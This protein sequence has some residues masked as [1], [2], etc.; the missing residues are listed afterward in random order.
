MKTSRSIL[1]DL[2]AGQS[3]LVSIAER[4][5]QPPSVLSAFLDD[6]I[7][8]GLV[9]SAPIGNPDIGR[10]LTVYRLTAAGR[11]VVQPQPV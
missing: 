8:D 9:E 11:D 10:T 6:L 4:L 3:T 7:I 1:R 2:S 5:R